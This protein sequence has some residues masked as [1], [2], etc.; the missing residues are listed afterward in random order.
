M[1][2]R[3][4]HII[5]YSL[6]A[7]V[8]HSCTEDYFDF[9]KLK[10]E[11]INPEIA[12][13]LINSS[14]SP[15]DIFTAEEDIE[16]LKTDQDGLITIFYNSDAFSIDTKSIFELKNQEYSDKVTLNNVEVIALP[17]QG[18]ITKSYNTSYPFE[19]GNNTRLDSMIVKSGLLKCNLVS[20]FQHGGNVKITFPTFKANGVPF[21]FNLPINYNGN[22]PV[23]SNSS[24]SLENFKIETS[25]GSSNQI[26][27]NYELTLNYSGQPISSSDSIGIT[28]QTENLE[29]DSFY[30][31]AGQQS[32]S[33]PEDTLLLNL[34][35]NAI[36]GT[37]NLS[38]PKLFIQ[39]INEFG[40]PL[41]LSFSKF[42]A[43]TTNSGVIPMQ[44]AQN[45]ISINAPST[46]GDSAT[47]TIILDK[48]NSNIPAVISAL[49][50]NFIYDF[51]VLTNPNG[52]VQQNFVQ[53]SNEAKAKIDL[54]LP[55]VGSV[56]RYALVDTLD[57]NFDDA[58]DLVKSAI[59]RTNITNSFPVD[60]NLQIYFTT[61]DHVILDSLFDGSKQVIQSSTVDFLGKTISPNNLT[62]DTKVDEFTLKNIFNSEKIIIK[63]DMS[64]SNAGQ[65]IVRF[66][67]Y[68]RLDVKLGLKAKFN[69]EID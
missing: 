37:F 52:D 8:L 69:I 50:K 59:F 51:S 16:V 33:F 28:I 29:F 41:E 6:C 31:Y 13:P 7:I 43:T 57:F 58:G 3:L 49:P 24:I 22:I 34:F 68:Y 61:Q 32:I 67:D 40:V 14:L 11:P 1:K 38:E 63:A 42:D 9:D 27:V 35:K 48:N 66:Y 62:I 53:Y 36:G 19:N 30:G 65:T 60:A 39:T 21:S 56:N 46:P 44:L 25:Q 47:T 23:Y 10:V 2:I 64:T 4:P 18:T 45:P 54:E 55:L 12:L 20:S 15:A 26:P 17:I 5:A